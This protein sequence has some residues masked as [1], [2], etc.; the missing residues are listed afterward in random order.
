MQVKTLALA[1]AL[2]ASIGASNAQPVPLE[3]KLAMAGALARP[4]G[5]T[6]DIRQVATAA[7]RAGIKESEIGYSV[8]VLSD[9]YNKASDE[10]KERLCLAGRTFAD[11][12]GLR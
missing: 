8:S 5:Y 12:L 1:A 9:L 3:T 7:I 10:Q 4:C 6:V 2:A 11:E